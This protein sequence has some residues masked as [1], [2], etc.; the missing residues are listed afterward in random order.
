LIFWDFPLFNKV[1]NPKLITRR[2]PVFGRK[3]QEGYLKAEGIV[4]QAR[5]KNWWILGKSGG[6]ME[7]VEF[8]KFELEVSIPDK[9]PYAVIHKQL[10]PFGV[11]SRLSKGMS[12]PV[13]VHP[14]KPRKLYLD[15]DQFAGAPQVQFMNTADLPE[16]I[17]DTLKGLGIE[18]EKKDP[19]IRL[20]ELENLYQEGL[21][22]E[23]E[24]K[25][26]RSEVLK[27]L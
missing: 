2:Q 16:E 4:G 20:K 19:K 14:E 24:Y 22:T 11:F 23:A 6:E 21:I 8:V 3:K 13:K 1:V 18:K 27:E 25:S 5:L 9:N 15:W 7:M 26:K 10:T 17:L 12:L